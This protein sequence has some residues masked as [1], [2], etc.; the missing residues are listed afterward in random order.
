MSGDV[1]SDSLRVSSATSGQRWKSS[2]ANDWSRL[3]T[4]DTER[5]NSSLEKLSTVGGHVMS[6]AARGGA[7][8]CRINIAA[9]TADTINRQMVLR[10]TLQIAY[11][12][13]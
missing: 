7:E 12:V 6:I 4:S 13:D 8:A 2:A 3:R 5:A 11:R 9:A 10:R 1:S